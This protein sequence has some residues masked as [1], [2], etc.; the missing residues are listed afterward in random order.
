MKIYLTVLFVSVTLLFSCTESLID[1]Q[2]VDSLLDQST[3]EETAMGKKGGCT[4][5]QFCVQISGSMTSD[6]TT[7]ENCVNSKTSVLAVSSS[8]GDNPP[9]VANISAL[10]TDGCFEI[11][12]GLLAL[13]EERN[14][15]LI[16]ME[17]YFRQDGIKYAF[18][19]K[20]VLTAGDWL[21]GE[22]ATID[23]SGMEWEIKPEK[24]RDRNKGCV[25]S[26]VFP[27]TPSTTITVSNGACAI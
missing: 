13:H 11:I 25:A 27:A 6:P 17:Y 8:A 24:G 3:S 10:D 14:N 16:R 18:V 12:S 9:M 1:G 21:P 19:A 4:V 26:G 22:E 23:F 2:K 20:G 7:V 15:G 5:T